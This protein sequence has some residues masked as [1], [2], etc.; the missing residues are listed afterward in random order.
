MHHYRDVTIRNARCLFYCHF[1]FS[2]LS[3]FFE[4][5]TSSDHN[6]A[7][8]IIILYYTLLCNNLA[9]YPTALEK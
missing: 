7:Q 5:L 9:M 6:E 1:P 2:C 4:W 3:K 8:I